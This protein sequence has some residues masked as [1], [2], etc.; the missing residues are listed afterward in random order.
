MKTVSSTS[1]TLSF[2]TSILVLILII[3]IT[4]KFIFS[5]QLCCKNMPRESNI[6]YQQPIDWFCYDCPY[7]LIDS[8]KSRGWKKLNIKQIEDNVKRYNINIDN[9]DN[10][11]CLLKSM[12]AKKRLPCMKKHWPN[13][14]K[15]PK[16]LCWRT[17][18]YKS[19]SPSV[20]EYTPSNA[21]T[22]FNIITTLSPESPK[23]E[24]VAKFGIWWERSEIGKPPDK[25]KSPSIVFSEP[26]DY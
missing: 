12:K 5:R 2:I 20:F 3:I 23:Y 24:T 14:K 7:G 4:W 1:Y 8:D 17:W 18:Y 25:V 22:N 9:F 26:I 13:I 10:F 19:E 11:E 21:K 6:Q 16:Y 15:L